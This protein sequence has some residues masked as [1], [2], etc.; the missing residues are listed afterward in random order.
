MTYDHSLNYEDAAIELDQLA[1]EIASLSKNLD[2]FATKLR[3][4]WQ[5]KFNAIPALQHITTNLAASLQTLADEIY[6]QGEAESKGETEALCE[7]FAR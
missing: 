3:P 4:D 5:N 6:K 2:R 1:V 7:E